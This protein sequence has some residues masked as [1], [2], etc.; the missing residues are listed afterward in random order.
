M[1]YIMPGLALLAG[2]HAYTYACWL[3]RNGNRLGWFGVMLLVIAGV[4]VPLYRFFA[5]P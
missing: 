5:V 3:K 4:G 2:F 1:E